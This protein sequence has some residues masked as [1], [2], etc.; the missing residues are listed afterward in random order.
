MRTPA[1]VLGLVVLIAT[2]PLDILAQEPPDSARAERQRGIECEQMVF[3]AGV[4]DKAPVG[5]SDA[6]PSDIYRVYCYV[7]VVGG[8]D[9]TAIV[10]TWYHGE[11][12][13]A[14]VELSVKAAR[15]RTWSSKRMAA[16]WQGRWRVEVTTADGAVIGS[17]EFS[18]E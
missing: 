8:E 13:M 9:T 15:W 10:H 3:C 16:G 12:K 4:K 2:N 17:K 5:V 14:T 7:T 11:T 1:L 18:L 6:F